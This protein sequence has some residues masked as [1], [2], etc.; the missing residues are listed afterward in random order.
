MLQV[1]SNIP[2]NSAQQ[3]SN[4]CSILG[5]FA[6]LRGDFKHTVAFLLSFGRD[7]LSGSVL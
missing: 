6:G 3:V 2:P 4:S 1:G 5:F 7:L